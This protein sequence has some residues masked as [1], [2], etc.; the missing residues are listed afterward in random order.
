MDAVATALGRIMPVLPVVPHLPQFSARVLVAEDNPVNQ[1]VV[2]ALLARLGVQ[3]EIVQDGCEAL[4]ARTRGTWDIV[5]MDCQMPGLD[6]F[7]AT[8]S[9]RRAEGASGARRVPIIALT[10]NAL[11]GDRELCLEA[12]MD[13][14]LAKPIRLESLLAMFQKWLTAGPAA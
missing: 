4:G 10:A 13:D 12:G 14:Y 9:W 2:Q 11:A 3:V 1:R 6:G 5:F 7:E 8:R